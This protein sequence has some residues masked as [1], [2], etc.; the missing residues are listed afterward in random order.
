MV[1]EQRE[2]KQKEQKGDKRFKSDGRA[3]ELHQHKGG[4][5]VQ[6]RYTGRRAPRKKS[7]GYSEV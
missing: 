2:S 3:G 4:Q 7:Q 6:W 1:R 5:I